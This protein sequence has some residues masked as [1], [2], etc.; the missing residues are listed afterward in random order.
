MKK[1]TGILAV[2]LA[3]VLSVSF[4]VPASAEGEWSWSGV[5]HILPASEKDRYAALTVAGNESVHY[6]PETSEGRT[7]FTAEGQAEQLKAT[8]KPVIQRGLK[9]IP[10]SAASKAAEGKEGFLAQLKMQPETTFDDASQ[11]LYYATFEVPEHT[12]PMATGYV[13][14]NPQT[15]DASKGVS[16]R[17]YNGPFTVDAKPVYATKA[18]VNVDYQQHESRMPMS[19]DLLTYPTAVDALEQA[20]DA[21]DGLTS[22]NLRP[23]QDNILV[24]P[25]ESVRVGEQTYK[26]SGNAKEGTGVLWRFAIYDKE[27]S[28]KTLLKPKMADLVDVEDGDTVVWA[29]TD[30][31][32]FPKSL[33]STATEDPATPP[34]G[35]PMDDPTGDHGSEQGQGEV[36]GTNQFFDLQPRAD[37]ANRQEVAA[38]FM[39]Q[40]YPSAES[41]IIVNFHAFPDAISAGNISGGRM[42]ILYTDTDELF[43]VTK[44]A[45][46]SDSALRQVIVLGG[47]VSVSH[48]VYQEIQATV[49]SSVEVK[50]IGGANR[51]EVNINTIDQY[52]PEATTL[53]VANGRDFADPL[54]ATPLAQAK[55][56]PVVLT[57][58][59]V[60]KELQNYLAKKKAER[61]DQASET[62]EMIIVGGPKTIADQQ[63]NELGQMLGT[64]P[65]R[66]SGKNRYALAAHVAQDYFPAA[67]GAVM[68]S[69]RVF[70]DALIG[71]PLAQ[72]QKFPIVLQDGSQTLEPDLLAYL[73]GLKPPVAIQ[74][75]GGPKTIPTSVEDFLKSLKISAVSADPSV[76]TETGSSAAD[77]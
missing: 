61:E 70:S 73:K 12:V 60:P 66:E 63:V 46:K 36:P 21:K 65:T 30:K 3:L 8:L 29:L 76:E 37:G 52:M 26:E 4:A 59:A 57:D 9:D 5:K 50:R 51:Y 64:T 7:Y 77:Q 25:V 2:A 55:S 32:A 22:A 48:A 6:Q 42:P 45:M 67:T 10:L 74:I 1:A 14:V 44:E 19:N 28:L 23:Y 53:V 18:G 27:G 58:Q 24:P 41:V 13:A 17:I 68:A 69:G 47:P 20:V 71:A 15:P 16:V 34:S 72:S 62:P 75:M 43:E 39:A 40:H 11:G 56:A 35:D 49:G 31:S 54:T 33:T 38:K